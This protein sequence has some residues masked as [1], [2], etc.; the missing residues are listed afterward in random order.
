MTNRRKFLTLIA[1]MMIPGAVLAA[2][3]ILATVYLNP[4]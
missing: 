1:A 2:E 4:T 3:P